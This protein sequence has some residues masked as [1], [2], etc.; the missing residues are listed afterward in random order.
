VMRCPVLAGLARF[1]RH[2]PRRSCRRS[3]RHRAGWHPRESGSTALRCE[4]HLA[5]RPVALRAR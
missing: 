5:S 1:R 2:G 4:F 3:T